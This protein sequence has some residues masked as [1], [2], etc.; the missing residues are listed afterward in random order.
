MYVH[1]FGCG[2]WLM[3]V[4]SRVWIPPYLFGSYEEFNVYEMD[5]FAK[6]S[7][8]LHGAMLLMTGND[9][10]PRNS[11]QIIMGALGLFLGAVIN[12]NIFG[13]L[14]VLIT[15]VSSKNNDF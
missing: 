13:E 1:C 4:R 12:A 11:S 10:G 7:A 5:S 2:W 9:V 3:V 14:A 15:S 8:S 6:Y